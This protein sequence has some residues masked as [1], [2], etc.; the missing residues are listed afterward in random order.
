VTLAELAVTVAVLGVLGLVARR[1]GLSAI[2]AYL[3][4]GLLLGPNEPEQLALIRPSE[5][6]KFVAELGI[7][8][9]LFFLGLEFTLTRL[10]GSGRHLGLGGTVDLA[11]NLG[12]GLVVGVAAFG[13]TFAALILAACVYVSSSAIAVK[14]LIDFRR[15]G[16]DETDLV[17][18]I[19]VFEDIVVAFMLGFAA[20]GGGD[21]SETLVLV[22]KA[23]GFITA[24]LAASRWL[25]GPI[26]RAL[27]RLTLEF[28]LLAVF[29]FLIGSAAVAEELG[30][31]AAIGA[32]MAGLVLSETSVR[33]QIEE[34]FFSFRDIFAALFFFVFGLSIDLGAIGDVGWLV[35]LAVALTLV[36][37]LSGG[38]IAGRLGGFTRRQSLNAGVALVAHGEFTII[39]A[40]VA[41]EN[42]LLEPA[43]REE[44]VAFAGLYVLA[45][46]TVGLV[47]MKESKRLGRRLFPAPRPTL[48]EEA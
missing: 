18:A 3:L 17:L 8:F 30:L 11:A 41:S 24:G 14:G 32:L 2:P 13:F 45:T 37:K 33:D 28:F 12:L 34:R 22:A 21:V 23:L 16:D 44:L 29:G 20:A 39:L 27:D 9:L 1:V 5:V 46:A 4:A 48:I 15:L 42:P 38:M 36:G 43:Q 7:V 31:S 25:S 10:R 47:L 6:T 26:D 19:L 40:Q 35:A